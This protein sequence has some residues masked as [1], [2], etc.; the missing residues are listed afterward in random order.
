[1]KPCDAVVL[2]HLASFIYISTAAFNQANIGAYRDHTKCKSVL[3]GAKGSNNS[4]DSCEHGL[5]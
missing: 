4:G 5:I 3:F 1:M 2:P